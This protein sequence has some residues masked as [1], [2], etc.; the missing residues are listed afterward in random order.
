[1]VLGSRTTVA[2]SCAGMIVLP[3]AFES[4][5]FYLYLN[6]EPSFFAFSGARLWVFL[7][8]ELALGFVLGRAFHG[9]RLY[10]SA[11]MIAI[12]IAV[13][14]YSLYHLCDTRQCYYAGPDGA[15]GIRL[16]TLL[17][18]A[19]SMGLFMGKRSMK[20]DNRT[21]EMGRETVLFGAIAAVLVGYFPTGLLFATFMADGTGLIVLGFAPTVPFFFSGIVCY[22]MAGYKMKYALYSV[23]GAWAVLSALFVGIRPSAA[24]VLL[25]MLAG[26]VP[27]ALLGMKAATQGLPRMGDARFSSLIFPLMLGIFAAT[28]VHPYLDAPM[29]L[30][31]HPEEGMLAKPTYYSGAYH[32]SDT[33][34][35]TKR[36]EVGIEISQLGND[37]KDFVLAGIGAQSP[38]CCKDGLDYGYRADLLLA[39]SETYLVAR[40]WETCDQNIACS[41]YPWISTMHESKVVL[42]TQSRSLMLAMEWEQASKEVNWYFR[43]ES[44][45]WSKY[46]S[47]KAPIIEN[48]YFNLGVIWAGMPITN[49]DAGNAFFFQAGVSVPDESSIKRTVTFDCP[50]YYDDKGDKHCAKMSP[51]NS[52]NSHWK[53]LWKWGVQN[54][55]G[56]VST[57]GSQITV[58]LR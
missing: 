19:A 24:P 26:G 16:A 12:I 17:F 37:I 33:Y 34:F 3:V 7:A 57:K 45:N 27:T 42:P 36:V 54:E 25:I 39:G 35:S 9:S 50:A 21:G 13:L 8:S 43:I 23:V 58:D 46:S 53:V 48:P 51:I 29:D 11:G 22:L 30:S 1:M 55:G 32:Q 15:G 28:A 5:T 40:A 18:T 4:F 31:T 49:P 14:T 56:E 2:L 44:G 6:R 38:N 47:F 52:G 41:G 20:N 10:L